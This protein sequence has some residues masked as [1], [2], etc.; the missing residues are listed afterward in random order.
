MHGPFWANLVPLGAALGPL[1]PKINSPVYVESRVANE[2]SKGGIS[3]LAGALS[4]DGELLESVF[5]KCSRLAV[6]LPLLPGKPRTEPLPCK[7]P[8]KFFSPDPGFSRDSGGFCYQYLPLGRDRRMRAAFQALEGNKL[9]KDILVNANFSRHVNP[10]HRGVIMAVAKSHE[11]LDIHLEHVKHDTY[12][13]GVMEQG[14]RVCEE[15]ADTLMRS[16]FTLCPTSS[17]TMDTTRFWDALALGSIPIVFTDQ[18][19]VVNGC[20]FAEY[21]YNLFLSHL[22]ELYVPFLAISLENFKGMTVEELEDVWSTFN[23]AD[24]NFDCLTLQYWL[25]DMQDF[26]DNSTDFEAENAGTEYLL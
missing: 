21:Q 1:V 26:I 22:V 9:E 23:D 15:Y 17:H 25:D 13:V 5:T 14:P 3:D 20:S 8:I 18:L 7:L 16:K 24:W 6:A 10:S 11:Y 12:G 19:N 4:S 2:V